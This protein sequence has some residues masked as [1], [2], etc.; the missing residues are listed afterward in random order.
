MPGAFVA[1]V[2]VG[3]VHHSS[4]APDRTPDPPVVE[5]HRRLKERFDPAGRLNPG[6]D[7]LA[8]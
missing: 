2:G 1:E 4:P 3:I 6:I 5:L 7:P 8:P